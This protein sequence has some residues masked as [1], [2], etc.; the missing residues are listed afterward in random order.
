MRGLIFL[1]A[2]LPIFLSATESVYCLHGFMR[3]PKSMQPMAKAFQREGYEAYSWGYPSKD[4]TI[5]EHATSLVQEL[6]ATAKSNLNEPIH[7]VTHSLGGIIVRAALNHPDCPKE[8][9]IGRAV[10]LGPP[11][12]GSHFGGTVG[13][14]KP[15]QKLLGENAGSELLMGEPFD[16]VGQFPES[17]DVLV[18]SGTFGWN[19]FAGGFNDGLVGV[20]ETSLKTPHKQIMVFS[21]HAWI[22]YSDTVIN[23]AVK[24]ISQGAFE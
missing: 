19:P 22:M 6:Q 17:M 8:A 14:V 13:K 3:S 11:N 12:Q 15:V 21:G 1:L 9:K 20:K 16:Y 7:F 18:I 2:F 24:F 10:L 5:E 4:K 23:H